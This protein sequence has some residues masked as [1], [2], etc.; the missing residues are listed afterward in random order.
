M[1]D[2]ERV[3]IFE[4]VLATGRFVVR[5]LESTCLP[6]LGNGSRRTSS[7]RPPY[8]REGVQ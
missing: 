7:S 8:S 2:R 5:P 1:S 6:K 3:A 4:G